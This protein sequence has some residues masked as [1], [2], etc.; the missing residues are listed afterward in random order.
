MVVRA[1]LTASPSLV[2]FGRG[3]FRFRSVTPLPVLALLVFLLWRSRGAPA[4]EVDRTLDVL[5]PLLA[6]GGAALRFWVTG[7]VPDGTSGQNDRLEAAVLNTRGPYAY[8][9]NPLY[10]GNL[11]LVLGLLCVANDVW[12]WTLGLAFFFGAY[13]FIV[14]AEEDFLRQKFPHAFEDYCAKV[15]RWVPRATPAFT[16]A[17]REGPFDWRR[18]LKKEHNPVMAFLTGLLF[19]FAWESGQV[20]LCAGLE[21]L[22]LVPYFAIKAWKHAR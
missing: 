8:V 14:R 18:A 12:V 9:R 10:L 17:L 2:A 21:A 7:S 19:L 22:L 16:G 5:G 15:P 13:A 20:A 4:T 3:L 6:L 11:G 1:P